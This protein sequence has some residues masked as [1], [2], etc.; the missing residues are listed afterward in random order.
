MKL[1]I[2]AISYIISLVT[3]FYKA[4]AQ[5]SV[6]YLKAM[7]L[8][9]DSSLNSTIL[10][11]FNY[12]YR[13]RNVIRFH[14]YLKPSKLF[15]DSILMKNCID[16]WQLCLDSIQSVYMKREPLHLILAK[17]Q[18]LTKGKQVL[19]FISFEFCDIIFIVFQRVRI[20]SFNQEVEQNLNARSAILI[21]K[22]DQEDNIKDYD[23]KLY[24]PVY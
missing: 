8:V 17:K 23:I 15:L 5:V 3:I 12:K 7:T 6:R 4:N 1:R 18:K 20:K 13:R 10:K 21:I 22:F 9:E 2:F 16:G 24:R 11:H 19:A 14:D